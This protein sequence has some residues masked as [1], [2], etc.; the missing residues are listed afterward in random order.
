MVFTEEEKKEKRR[1]NMKRQYEKNKEKRIQQSKDK[2][3]ANREKILAQTKER[4]EENKE[5]MKAYGRQYH[6]DNKEKRSTQ[7]KVYYEENKETIIERS[8]QY[9][10]Q[11]RIDNPHIGF[12]TKWKSRGL[13]WDTE[14][15]FISIWNEYVNT[16]CCSHCSYVFDEKNWKCMDH[17]HTT[18]R[19]R[20]I[21]CWVCN[22]NR[23]TDS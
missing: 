23:V 9:Q 4:Y 15:E 6:N 22:I 8:K 20:T 11:Y 10:P 12:K 7:M 16:T 1:L 18:H 21:L 14:E 17:D 5:E 19:F 2:Y 13:I 3:I